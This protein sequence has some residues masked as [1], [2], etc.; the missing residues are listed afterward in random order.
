[1]V[2]SYFSSNFRATKK[3]KKIQTKLKLTMNDRR[4]KYCLTFPFP[5]LVTSHYLLFLI[6]SLFLS[7]YY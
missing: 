4:E 3:K 5:T 6:T 7:H 2:N 1:M